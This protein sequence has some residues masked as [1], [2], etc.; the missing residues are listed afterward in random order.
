M[1]E[2]IL[3]EATLLF[4]SSH[5]GIRQNPNTNTFLFIPQTIKINKQ[6]HTILITNA[7]SIDEI[8]EIIYRLTRTNVITYSTTQKSIEL[9]ALQ[10]TT[11]TDLYT[12]NKLQR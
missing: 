10:K 6:C 12:D 8:N 7:S 3:K 1:N 5:I 4:T 11:F 2:Q 9:N